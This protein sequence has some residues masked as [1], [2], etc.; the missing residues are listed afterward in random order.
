[1]TTVA[2]RDSFIFISRLFPE[3]AQGLEK[4]TKMQ[5]EQ[6][7]QVE[8]ASVELRR[9]VDRS[10]PLVEDLK[11]KVQHHDRKHSGRTGG[12]CYVEDRTWRGRAFGAV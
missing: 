3:Q 7:V 8:A 6:L 11:A 2:M 1:M 5:A 10:E 12:G 4:E 9:R